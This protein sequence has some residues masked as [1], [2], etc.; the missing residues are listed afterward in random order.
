MSKKSLAEV[1]LKIAKEQEEERK[2][3]ENKEK[4]LA[5]KIYKEVK[6]KL[7]NGNFTSRKSDFDGAYIISVKLKKAHN[8]DKK[9]D[10]ELFVLLEAKGFHSAYCGDKVNLTIKEK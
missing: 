7:K 1:T 3:L 9:V 4:I 8:Y 10:E 5:K 2:R 6:K